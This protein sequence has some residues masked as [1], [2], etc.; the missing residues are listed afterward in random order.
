MKQSSMYW[1]YSRS[2]Y[3]T[4]DPINKSNQFS[5]IYLHKTHQT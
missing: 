3:P 1:W 2:N 4:M 5:H